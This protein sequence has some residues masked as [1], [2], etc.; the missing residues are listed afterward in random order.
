MLTNPCPCCSGA[1]GGDSPRCN[2][3]HFSH[4]GLCKIGQFVQNPYLLNG[5]RS[6]FRS[7]ACCSVSDLISMVILACI[8]S[9]VFKFRVCSI[10]IVMTAFHTIWT[11]AGK[12]FKNKTVNKKFF[13]YTIHAKR[14]ALIS[15]RP[16]PGLQN[17]FF[18]KRPPTTRM[19]NISANSF[20]SSKIRR[21]I[22]AFISNNWKPSFCYT[23]ICHRRPAFSLGG[24]RD[25]WCRPASSILAWEA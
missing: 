5:F 17:M 4:F 8:P 19:F 12:R 13:L 7:V 21:L 9:Q 2:A 18:K 15:P 3:V 1:N 11:W 14:Y 24:S 6:K 23:W 10:A 20:Y 25:G 22:K 16:D